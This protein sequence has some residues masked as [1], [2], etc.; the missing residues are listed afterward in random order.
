MLIVMQCSGNTTESKMKVEDMIIE[1]VWEDIPN[2]ETY[3][4]A[5]KFDEWI[6]MQIK[7]SAKEASYLLGGGSVV[8]DMTRTSFHETTLLF[9]EYVR[10][11]YEGKRIALIVQPHFMV[12][13]KS[14]MPKTYVCESVHSVMDML[15]KMDYLFYVKKRV[16][17]SLDFKPSYEYLVRG[18]KKD[19]RQLND[20]D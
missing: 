19:E 2:T 4:I 6:L 10:R 14:M 15:D 13:G 1:K 8:S 9:I 3:G 20:E 17:V 12:N 11:L 5:E 16:K 18:V 7:M